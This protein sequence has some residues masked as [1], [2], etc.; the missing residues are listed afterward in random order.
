MPDTVI[1]SAIVQVRVPV[2]TTPASLAPLVE[3]VYTLLQQ[4]GLPIIRGT[5]GVQG[6]S[7]THP[8]PVPST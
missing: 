2:G 5:I 3:Q 7:A 6:A 8:V 1:A 4:A